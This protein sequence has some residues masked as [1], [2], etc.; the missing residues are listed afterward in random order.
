[1]GGEGEFVIHAFFCSFE[2]EQIPY[3]SLRFFASFPFAFFAVKFV[4]NAKGA[5]FFRK[6]REE[7]S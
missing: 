6:G 5:K 4:F 2:T 3:S 7:I 1:V